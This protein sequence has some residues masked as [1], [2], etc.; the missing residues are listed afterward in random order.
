MS[1]LFFGNWS[2]KAASI[3]Q[4]NFAHSQVFNQE[5]PMPSSGT[6]SNVEEPAASPATESTVLYVAN[7]D[8]TTAILDG[9]TGIC[10]DP[11]PRQLTNSSTML[12]IELL[13]AAT[14]SEITA[15]FNLTDCLF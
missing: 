11:G 12:C 1:L 4:L 8:T 2:G 10:L 3:A 7:K 6:D 14:F 5:N 15:N 9:S 13:G